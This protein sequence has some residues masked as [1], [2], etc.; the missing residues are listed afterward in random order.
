MKLGMFS[1][2][3]ALSLGF[4]CHKSSESS[5]TG[6]SATAGAQQAAESWLALVDQGK[7]DESWTES[8]K[9]FQSGVDQA[10]WHQM[11]GAVRG[12]LGG[13]VFRKLKSA[14]FK[15]SLPGAPDGK[16]V[17][18]QYDTSFA[19]RSAAVETITPMVD[20][21]GKWKVSGYFIR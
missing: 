21:D 12:P 1:L 18:I 2:A 5:M 4:G 10:K 19:N 15:T 13:L 17:V 3:I 7:Y 20:T 14:D 11:V 16:Y 8:A 6:E 9:I